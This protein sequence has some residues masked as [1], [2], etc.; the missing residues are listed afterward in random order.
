MYEWLKRR[1][2]TWLILN[3]IYK[4]KLGRKFLWLRSEKR[5]RDYK[6]VRLINTFSLSL[7]LQIHHLV[8]YIA[9][10]WENAETHVEAILI[11]FIFFNR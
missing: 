4:K 2:E 7:S 8:Y 9:E 11:L 3:E 1:D 5:R 10:E 6:R